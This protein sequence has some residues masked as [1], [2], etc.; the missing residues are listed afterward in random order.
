MR[1]V[2]VYSIVVVA[3]LIVPTGQAEE[4]PTAP[5]PRPA[6]F[7]AAKAKQ[8]LIGL[9]ETREQAPVCRADIKKFGEVAVS[10]VPDDLGRA[11]WGPF[12][13][14]LAG[15]RYRFRVGSQPG[16]PGFWF[17]EYE[18]R[19]ELQGGKWVALPFQMTTHG[20]GGNP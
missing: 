1:H 3:G 20:R 15:M 4:L 19:F 18:G 7:T 13:L 8:A 9:M 14:D 12:T 11:S 5:L 17:M 16:Q 6:G 2:S 10:V